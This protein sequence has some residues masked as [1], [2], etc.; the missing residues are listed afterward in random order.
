MA[1]HQRDLRPPS[2]PPSP[3]PRDADFPRAAE[4]LS[5]PVEE[6]RAAVV[7]LPFSGLSLSG[8]RCDLLPDAL[9][10][11][12]WSLS[13]YNAG[14]G[15]DLLD[16][17]AADLGDVDL[18]GLSPEAALGRIESA[19]SSLAG[20]PLA[21]IGGDNSVTA[22][23]VMGSVGSDG[24]LLTL[25]AHHD[26]RDYRRDGLS[27][28]SPVRVILDSGIDGSRIWQV[29][30]RD[31]ANSRAYS[32]L[33]DKE[34]ITVFRAPEVRKLGI[35]NVV[36]QA[37]AELGEHAVYVD[38]DL[39]VV[40]LSFAPGAPAAQPGG[41]EP[42][43]ILEAA[44]ICGSHPSVRAMDIVEVDP[45]RDAGGI[46]VRLAALALLYFLSGVSRR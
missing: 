1:P 41:L 8:A 12:L 13:T 38:L 15:I 16:L 45:L 10:A 26:L 18:Q 3:F 27:N 23:A 31:F 4:W 19:I 35:S 40:D 14:D 2:Y 39:D 36:E 24:A 20:P 32:D 9:R 22:P 46:T 28:G 34:G 43:D 29:G 11:A 5:S 25:D 7:G 33:A 30:I 37:L 21:L 6:P 17:E 44:F 42:A